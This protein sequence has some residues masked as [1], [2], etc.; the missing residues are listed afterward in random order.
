L[1]LSIS[2]RFA[3]ILHRHTQWP[4]P[5]TFHEFPSSFF[6]SSIFFFIVHKFFYI[7]LEVKSNN[8]LAN[9][10]ILVDEMVTAVGKILTAVDE[11]LAIHRSTLKLALLE[12]VIT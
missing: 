12:P 4:A 1:Y 11:I 2:P 8:N 3:Q 10:K 7:G 9:N 6:L 5:G